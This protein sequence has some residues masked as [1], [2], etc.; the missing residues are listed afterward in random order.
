MTI[1]GQ[2]LKKKTPPSMDDAFDQN[3]TPKETQRECV[4]PEEESVMVTQSQNKT[5]TPKAQTQSEN[6]KPY[7]TSFYEYG[8]PPGPGLH[9]VDFNKKKENSTIY[10]G[11]NNK[12]YNN[13][14]NKGFKEKHDQSNNVNTQSDEETQ[15]P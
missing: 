7:C 11:K 3:G 9:G 12:G 1:R 10:N 4:Y 8:F 14:S 5:F 15:A 2:I 6:S 13:K